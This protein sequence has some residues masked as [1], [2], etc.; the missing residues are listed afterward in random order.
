MSFWPLLLR[1]LLIVAF[2]LNG[3][4]AAAGAATMGG[5][6]ASTSEAER[7][8]T[9]SAGHTCHEGVEANMPV[10]D[11]APQRTEPDQQ[12]KPSAPDCCKQ[13]SC[14]CACMGAQAGAP[15]AHDGAVAPSS[16]RLMSPLAKGHIEPATLHLI[17][18]PIG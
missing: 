13:S 6:H 5:T 14:G 16:D 9:P 18:P 1:V 17:R 11:E 12:S 15:T 7:I 3:T 4:T 8:S 2:V 10:A